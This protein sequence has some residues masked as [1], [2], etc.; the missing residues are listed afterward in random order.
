MFELRLLGPVEINVHG[1]VV[2]VGPPQRRTVLAA[3]AVDLGRGVSVETLIDRV[4]DSPPVGARRALHAHIARIRRVLEGTSAGQPRSIGLA[5]RNGEYLL[6]AQPAQVDMHRFLRLVEHGRSTDRTDAARVYALREALH[7]WRGAPMCGLPGQWA[8]GE[9]ERWRRLRLDALVA[10]ADAELRNRADAPI[11][12]RLYELI[13]E[14]PLAE[15]LV[16]SLM[17]AL[18]SAGRSA[19]A[20]ECFAAARRRLAEELGIEPGGALRTLHGSILRGDSEQGEP[21]G[22]GTGRRRLD[23]RPGGT[24]ASWVRRR[25]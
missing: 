24:V 18:C 25:R 19:E 10:W 3:L 17:R 20:A 22:A 5:R 2:D 23:R 1:R 21:S 6:D 14:Y 4:W 9:R 11:V 15:P 12:G 13:D 7:L 8:M 16:A